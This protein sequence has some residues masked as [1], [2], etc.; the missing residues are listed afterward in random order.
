MWY[1][2]DKFNLPLLFA[3]KTIFGSETVFI[4]QFYFVIN[5]FSSVVS[6]V[7]RWT[8]YVSQ[9]TVYFWVQ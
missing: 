5:V 1:E 8:L 2:T 9:C 4:D 7:V 6:E 3:Y